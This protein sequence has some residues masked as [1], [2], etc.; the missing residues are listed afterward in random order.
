[1][2]RVEMI[3]ND[4]Q[5]QNHLEKIAV[6][7]E[8]RIFCKHNLTH[9][10]DVARIAYTFSLEQNLS[11]KK[12]IIYAAAL[13]HDI[14][15]HLQYEYGI[16]HAHA[17]ADLALPILENAG[18][19]KNEIEDIIS[20]IKKHR[21]GVELIHPLEQLIFHADKASRLCLACPSRSKCNKWENQSPI[22]FI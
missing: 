8:S 3:L 21:K 10:L 22:F 9:F 6:L 20:A 18:Y 4:K 1:M 19:V 7:E 2:L 12:D 13:L 14:G 15:R 17:S 11:I 16:D 5:F